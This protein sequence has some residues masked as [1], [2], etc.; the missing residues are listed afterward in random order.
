MNADLSDLEMGSEGDAERSG[1]LLFNN[2]TRHSG[3]IGY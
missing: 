3:H 1:R 2:N